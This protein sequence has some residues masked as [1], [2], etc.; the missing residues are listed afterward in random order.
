MEISEKFKYKN[1]TP[2]DIKNEVD[3]L[4]PKMACIGNDIPAKILI[5]NSGIV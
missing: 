5:G 1:I 3:K 4:N 2:E